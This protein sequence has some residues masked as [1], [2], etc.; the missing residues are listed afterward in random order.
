MFNFKGDVVLSKSWLNR[1]LIIQHYQ[2]QIQFK[3]DSDSEDV[4][5]LKKSLAQLGN[6][7]EFYLGQG[8]TSF[9][10]FCFLISKYPGTWVVKAHPRLLE[11][12]QQGLKNLL[13]QF[14]VRVDFKKEEAVIYSEGWR[15][16][17]VVTCQAQDSSQFI[18]ALLL[19]AWN[20]SEDLK[21]QIE[22]PIVSVDYLKMTTT[23]LKQF[24]LSL[25]EQG[26][27]LLIKKNQVPQ[28]SKIQSEV[29]VSSAFS[30]A[31][32]AVING[33][34][35]ITN[36]NIKSLQ[37]DL[38][39]LNLFTQM[40]IHYS[41]QEG[42]LKIQKQTGWKSLNADLNHAPDLFPVLAVL[43]AFAEGK[44]DLHGAEQLQHKESNR[45]LK[46]KELLD[47][48]GFQSDLKKDGLVIY[49]QSSTQDKKTRLQFNPDHDH[50]MAMAAG[51]LKLAGYNI[52]IQNPEVVNKSY[53][54]FWKDISI[55]P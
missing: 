12:P 21:V 26:T 5:V 2:P 25:E 6:S 36:W 46:T 39:F 48:A 22:G 50:R 16:P 30:L 45:L 55:K 41:Q 4:Q 7:S 10:F 42:S 8:G 11:R 49:G 33:E 9:R 13:Q 29:D 27:S 51:L 14:G 40:Q 37:P 43:C 31:A 3:A 35:E 38:V 20:L 32:A 53:P 24:G 23:M 54:S 28:I 52:D 15:L 19:N 34:V 44:S 1:A 17:S 18:S 47:L